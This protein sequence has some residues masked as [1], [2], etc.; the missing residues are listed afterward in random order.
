MQKVV[1]VVVLCFVLAGCG[2]DVSE[3]ELRDLYDPG[4][5]AQAPV[6]TDA[7][8]LRV[9]AQARL[10]LPEIR[11]YLHKTFTQPQSVAEGYLTRGMRVRDN[12]PIYPTQTIDWAA[13]PQNDLNW[14]FQKNA[15]YVLAPFIQAHVQTA[16]DAYLAIIKKVMLDWIDFNL[17]QNRVNPLK[18]DDMATGLRAV[19][20]A[21]LVDVELRAENLDIA[22][23]TPMLRAVVVHAAELAAPEKL[24][25]GNH[26]YFQLV[27]LMALCKA[28][29]ELNKCPQYA[30]YAS[31]EMDKLIARQF[32]A[33]GIHREHAPDYHFFSLARADAILAT[34]WFEISADSKERLAKA[35]EN[36]AWFRQPDGTISMIGDSS[37]GKPKRDTFISVMRS[38]AVNSYGRV[39]PLSGYA[40]LRSP[41]HER[42]P[43]EHSYLI[44]WAGEESS[45]E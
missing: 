1:F 22:S 9:M 8:L 32:S 7:D 45:G 31:M 6:L 40:M 41:W 33:E 27:G 44:F 24:A 14:L 37:R 20:L 15:T 12:P 18:W 25:K 13:N 39:F 19:N 2:E 42:P 10:Q 43:S 34:Q 28:V 38:D 11:F 17:T 3:L 4:S 16:N 30:E 23:L 5:S 36:S 29:P 26:A 21:Y 35:H